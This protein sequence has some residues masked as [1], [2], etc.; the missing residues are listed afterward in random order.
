MRFTL[1]ALLAVA[2]GLPALAQSR[3]T[4][5]APPPPPPS[6]NQDT[7]RELQALTER[8]RAIEAR[9]KAQEGKKDGDRKTEERKV[10]VVVVGKDGEPKKATGKEGVHGVIELK[11]DGDAKGEAGKGVF[12]IQLDG[13]KKPEP[14]K[15]GDRKPDG[16]QGPRG[17]GGGPGGP[18][19]GGGFGGGP[20]GPGGPPMGGMMMM[21][22]GGEGTPPGFDRL[23]KEEQEQ[24]RRLMAKMRGGDGP[25]TEVRVREVRREGSPE[26]GERRPQPPAERREGGDRPM[27][28][29]RPEGGDRR[30][31]LE[32]R[33]ERLERAI[34]DIRRAMPKK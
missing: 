21:R 24:F 7:L 4:P 28:E 23:S 14:K 30:P 11:L 2:L 3:P 19:M 10:E 15:D 6:A 27:A 20:G 26:G 17:F 13:D 12:V 8:L 18:P 16:P 33:M 25:N 32:E 1:S 29:R 9:L 31:N 5:P 34:E 22:M